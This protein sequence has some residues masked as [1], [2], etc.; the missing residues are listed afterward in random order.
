M[1]CHPSAGMRQSS[2]AQARPVFA[3]FLRPVASCA[4]RTQVG[5][6]GKL[7]L[8]V[9]TYTTHIANLLHQHQHQYQPHQL[10]QQQEQQQQ[11]REQLEWELAGWLAELRLV[12]LVLENCTF[13]CVENENELLELQVGAVSAGAAGGEGRSQEQEGLRHTSHEHGV[14]AWAGMIPRGWTVPCSVT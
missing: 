5:V 3:C 4:T 8:L 9:P 1:D 2:H 7:G 10:Q 6:L 12:L 14:I 11:G 13:T